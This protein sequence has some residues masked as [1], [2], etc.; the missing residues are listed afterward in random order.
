M[1]GTVKPQNTPG[2]GLTMI[3]TLPAQPTAQPTAQPR[4]P[5]Q[6]PAA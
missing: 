3:L 2:G 5:R 4:G 6:I 1:G